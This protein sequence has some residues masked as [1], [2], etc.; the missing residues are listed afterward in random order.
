MHITIWPTCAVRADTADDWLG[1]QL[2]YF[3]FAWST[4]T[5]SC[6]VT[7]WLRPARSTAQVGKMVLP[8][9]MHLDLSQRHHAIGWLIKVQIIVMTL[10][11]QTDVIVGKQCNPRSDQGLHCFPFR[12]HLFDTLLYGRT[13]LFKVKNNYSNFSGVQKF[14]NFT[15][16][17]NNMAD[18]Y[19]WETII[20]PICELRYR[21]KWAMSWENLF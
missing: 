11:F 21:F 6:V 1:L 13:T 7:E 5:F 20:P 12:L 3:I 15:D 18:F 17:L 14:R 19:L 8:L 4:A 16:D 10:S 2:F 9:C